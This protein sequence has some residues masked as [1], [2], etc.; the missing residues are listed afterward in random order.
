[1]SNIVSRKVIAFRNVANYKF[2][3]KLTGEQKNEIIE[4]LTVALGKDFKLIT[5]SS[6]DEQTIKKLFENGLI[7]A[8]SSTIFLNLKNNVCIDLFNGEHL[9]I[10]ASSLIDEDI[11]KNVQ[12]VVENIS[13]KLTLAY[14]DEYGYLSSNLYNIG[15]GYRLEADICLDSICS[16]NKIEQVKRNVTN[17]G[18][19][20]AE[21]GVQSTYKISTK[22]CLGIAEKELIEEFNKMVDKLQELEIESAKMLDISNHD[23]IY[24]K[25]LRSYAILKN[26]HLI[27]FEELSTILIIL[28]TGVNLGFVN[29]TSSQLS[30]LQALVL[31]KTNNVISKTECKE[32]ASSVKNI[33]KGE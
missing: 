24:D 25:I 8:K 26:C 33:L 18:Y 16:L 9:T 31:N 23:E 2:S 14:N 5:L 30:Q 27:N 17:L 6:A 22:C 11:V 7:N 1:M 20:L 21:T 19:G 28:R 29:L 13:N 12:S 4:K 3:H 10:V 15:S 32:L